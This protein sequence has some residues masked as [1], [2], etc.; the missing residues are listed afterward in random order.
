MKDEELE[1]PKIK[2]GELLA[3]GRERKIR[4]N[5]RSV[6]ALLDSVKAAAQMSSD[7]EFYEDDAFYKKKKR[8]VST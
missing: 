7:E 2:L 8:T 4:D 6:T 1:G 3:N 5:A